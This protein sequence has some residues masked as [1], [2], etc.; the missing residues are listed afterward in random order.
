M[1]ETY[2]NLSERPFA[3]VPR[4]EH[5]FPAANI[6]AARNSLVRCIE[7][8][9]GTA[10][11][12][13][14]SGTGKTL[15]CQLLAEQFKKPFRVV[16][17][18]SGHLSVR[19]ALLQA[20]LYE[21]GQPYRGMDE[22][23]L[24]LALADHILLSDDCRPGTV[25]LIDE[26]HLLPLRLLD[27]IRMLTNL[28]R[29]GQPAVRLALVGGRGLE[30]RFASP[31]LDSF[32]QRLAVRCYLESF[33]RS[34]T[35]DY[36]YARIAA[37]GGRGPQIF[38]PEAC[39][40]IHKATDGV[41]RLINQVCDH[42]LLLALAAGHRQIEPAHVEEAWADLQQLP[43]PWNEPSKKSAA[44]VIEFGGLEDESEEDESAETSTAKAP[45][46]GREEAAADDGP[47]TTL[48]ISQQRHAAESGPLEPD[49]QIHQ[50]QEILAG[51][52]EEFRPAGSIRP[53]IELVFDEP[54]NPF[55]ERFA[56]EEV[57][58]DRYA[59][60]SETV[61]A[62]PPA[63]PAEP[64]TRSNRSEDNGSPVPPVQQPTEAAATW[65]PEPQADTVP[66]HRPSSPQA[67]EPDDADILVIEE[68]YEEAPP[69]PASTVVPVRRQEYGRLFAKLRRGT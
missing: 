23:E 68:G 64:P 24:R 43:T 19:R 5:Y 28:M 46:G 40:S 42:V 6:E 1:Y 38:P 47:A 67:A 31:K 59:V 21:L 56:E 18:P 35:Q 12:I 17:L 51:V 50:I 26:A 8:A 54:E 11:V 20:I 44:G 10:I 52:E 36:V 33:G 2:F 62:Q 41:P 53:E 63:R 69:W 14:P 7:R 25:L 9:E 65:D 30:E 48:R 13:G 55:G 60:A 39:Q 32:S 58:S 45:A 37:A 57:L 49:V 15:L 3:S 16:L 4:V 61:A 27:E 22:G 29:D 34:E 66:M